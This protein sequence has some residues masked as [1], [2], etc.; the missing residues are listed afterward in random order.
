MLYLWEFLDLFIG[1]YFSQMELGIRFPVGE[2]NRDMQIQNIAVQHSHV[3][4]ERICWLIWIVTTKHLNIL[5]D[6]ERK[7]KRKP[8]MLLKFL[9]NLVNFRG[10]RPSWRLLFAH[11]DPGFLL[12]LDTQWS[13]LVQ[14]PLQLAETGDWVVVNRMSA[15]IR[16]TFVNLTP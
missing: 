2:N 4:E 8:C 5:K 10:Q 9:F 3:S 6:W 12:L 15:E 13:F 11:P 16:V 1:S 14:G 7:R